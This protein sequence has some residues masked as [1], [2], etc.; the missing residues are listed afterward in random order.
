M[1]VTIK[2]IGSL[3][4]SYLY[5]KF[6][7]KAELKRLNFKGR[8]STVEKFRATIDRL[9]RGSTAYVYNGNIEYRAVLRNGK[10]TIVVD[11]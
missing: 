1:S 2:I 3:E 10:P 11:E 4:E 7:T 8:Y 9:I 6:P 5:E